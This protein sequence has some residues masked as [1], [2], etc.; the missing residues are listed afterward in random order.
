M[1]NLPKEVEKQLEILFFDWTGME[2][3]RK[4]QEHS[5]AEV[6][7]ALLAIDKAAEKRVVEELREEIDALKSMDATPKMIFNH[8]QSLL[9]T[10]SKAEDKKHDNI[11]KS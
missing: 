1:T 5:V 10:Y 2:D 3:E 11:K 4:L 9:D 7:A 8:L 6:L